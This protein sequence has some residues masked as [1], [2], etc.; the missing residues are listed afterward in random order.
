MARRTHSVLSDEGKMTPE[1][2]V[3]PQLEHSLLRSKHV[4]HLSKNGKCVTSERRTAAYSVESVSG[5]TAPESD[6]SCVLPVR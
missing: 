6:C 2:S 1:M 4:Q 3:I 5:K